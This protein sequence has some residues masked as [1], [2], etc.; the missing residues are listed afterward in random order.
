MENQLNENYIICEYNINKEKL[1]ESIQLLNS[2]EEARKDD[3]FLKGIENE[4]ELKNKCELYL[5]NK[6]DFCLKY[7]FSSEGKY[8][9]KLIFKEPLKNSNYLFYKC[10][11]ISSLDLSKFNVNNIINMSGMFF[12]CSFLISLNLS[13]FNTVNVKDMSYMFRD[14]SSLNSLDVSY[15][16]TIN[17]KDMSNMFENCYSLISL[18]LSN[19]NTINVL[20]MTDMFS[21]CYSL[22]SLN[23]SNFNT[24]MFVI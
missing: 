8:V 4:M 15:L 1:S 9:I 2:Y 20:S 21:Y 23:L 3:S 19:F 14:C 5:N 7:K 12:N 16:N 17:V 6:I 24:I 13:N 18:D 22:K 11:Y 10:Y